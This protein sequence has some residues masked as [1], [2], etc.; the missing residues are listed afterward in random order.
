[1]SKPAKV[2]QFSHSSTKCYCRN[3]LLKLCI[4]HLYTSECCIKPLLIMFSSSVHLSSNRNIC[5]TLRKPLAT[6][7]AVAQPLKANK[8][9][10]MVSEN[11][12]EI[13]AR[14]QVDP[15]PKW[16]SSLDDLWNFCMWHSNWWLWEVC[17]DPNS[18]AL[19]KEDLRVYY[20]INQITTPTPARYD[21]FQI[22]S[23]ITADLLCVP[24][25][26]AHHITV[27]DVD[28]TS[29]PTIVNLV[30]FG[31]E[32]APLE[33]KDN[34][35]SSLMVTPQDMARHLFTCDIIPDGSTSYFMG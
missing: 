26:F 4:D 6:L 12:E 34:A 30:L 29:H 28:L 27:T 19:K 17:H 22:I 33:V 25:N 13:E 2:F 16:D 10:T 5:S 14:K 24:N 3:S 11:S 8:S 35:C 32:T 20:A 7:E 23:N 18:G 9:N 21:F 1:M 15:C 31:L